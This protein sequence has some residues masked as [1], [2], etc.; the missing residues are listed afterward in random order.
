METQEQDQPK[1]EKFVKDNRGWFKEGEPRP[2]SAGRRKGTPNKRT[3]M[4]HQ[5]LA[6]M[7]TDPAKIISRIAEDET[8]DVFVRLEAAKALMPFCYPRLSSVEVGGP[9]GGP[10]VSRLEAAHLHALTLDPKAR[11]LME[12][13]TFLIA[14]KMPT[15]PMSPDGRVTG[16][17]PQAAEAELLDQTDDDE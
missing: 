6:G 17:L 1:P 14:E 12:Q 2:A 7:D 8:L 16:L 4:R 5:L 3:V 11:D 10:I 13:I 15:I 9:G